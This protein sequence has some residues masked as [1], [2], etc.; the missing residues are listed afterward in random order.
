MSVRRGMNILDLLPMTTGLAP[1][2]PDGILEQIALLNIV[3]HRSTASPGFYLHE[4][5]L[6]SIADQFDLNT[7]NWM[8]SVPGVATGLPFRLSVARPPAFPATSGGVPA[9]GDFVQEDIPVQWALDIKVNPVSVVLPGLNAATI[10]S[11]DPMKTPSLQAAGGPPAARR[12]TLQASCVLRISGGNGGTLVQLMDAPDPLDPN[13]PSGGVVRANMQPNTAVIGNSQFGFKLDTLVADVSPTFTPAEIEARGKDES[14]MGISLKEL[15]FFLPL[16]TP[17]VDNM[18]VGGRDLLVGVPFGMQGEIA[19]DFSKDFPQHLNTYL[20]IEQFDAGTLSGVPVQTNPPLYAY[21]VPTGPQ[22]QLQRVR[23]K[24]NLNATIG[25]GVADMKVIGVWWEIPGGIEGNSDTTPWFDAPTDAVLRYRLRVVDATLVGQPAAQPSLPSAIPSGQTELQQIT[26]TFPRQSGSPSGDPPIV[27]ASANG[28]PLR[29]NVLH[30]R[31]PAHLLRQ[32]ALQTRNQAIAVR[33][34]LGGGSVPVVA[35]SSSTFTLAGL[36]NGAGPFELLVTDD[37]GEPGD[38]QGVRRIRIDV[39][40]AGPLAIGHQETDAAASPGLVSLEGEPAPLQPTRISDTFLA[41]EYHTTGARSTAPAPATLAGAKVTTQQG[42]DAEVEVLVP[43]GDNTPVPVPPTQVYVTRT[44]QVL[45]Q[46]GE[47]T[48]IALK[49]E[50]ENVT[51]APPGQSLQ[52]HQPLAYPMAINFQ[53][54]NGPPGATLEQQVAAWIAGLEAANPGVDR[55]FYVVG[56]T[57][58]LW[59]GANQVTNQQKN[60]ELA[61]QRKERAMAAVLAVVNDPARVMGRRETEAPVNWPTTLQ[62]A[63]QRMLDTRRLALPPG[64]APDGQPYL[65]T[66]ANGTPVWRHDWTRDATDNVQSGQHALAK[67]DL[68]RA[69][70]RCAEIFAIEAGQQ[71]QPS[72]P[73]PDGRSS[74]VTML[75]PGADGPVTQVV[76]TTPSNAQNDYRI[77]VK[78]RWDSPSA[79]GAADFIPTLAEAKVRW[80][81]TDTNLPSVGGQ[82]PALSSTQPGGPDYWEVLLNWAY[83]ASTGQTEATGALSIPYGKLQLI[84]DVWA[85]GL[86][87][88]PALAAKLD[89]NDITGT[90]AGDFVGGLACIAA[91]AV[92][93]LFINKDAGPGDHHGSVVFEKFTLSYKWNGA[94]HAAATTDYT[95]DLRIKTGIAGVFIVQGNLKLKYQGVGILFDGDDTGGLQDISLCMKDL[96]V[97]VVDPG[98]WTLGGPLGDLIRVA[99]S[100]LGNGS[101]WMEFDLEF[102]IDLG[103]IRLEG[104]VIRMRFESTPD[105]S[106]VELRGLTAV[107]EV[108][109]TLN[110]KGSVTIGDGGAFRAMLA[111][112]VIP[113][114]LSA[115]GAL[116]V[117]HDFVSVEVGIQL[118]VGIPLG[119]TGF[120]LFGFMGRFVANGTRDL[121]ACPHPDPVERQ[122]QWYG[123]QPDKKY[124]RL[125][126]QFAFGVGAVI[127]TL[128]DGGFSFNAEG[129][130]TLGFPDISVVFSI[131]AHLISQRK[132]Q[133]TAQGSNSGSSTR[134]LGMVVIEPDALMIAV[135]TTYKIPKIL[136]LK[137]PISAYF[138]LAGSNLAWYIRIGSDNG[139]GR[140]GD[141]VTIV[142]FPE[143]LDVKAWAFLM[144]EERELKQLGGTL[145]PSWAHIP[146]LDFDGFSI[147]F[148]AGFD[149]RWEAGPFS[150]EISAFMV[151]GLGTKPLLCAGAAGVSGSLDLVVVTLDVDGWLYFRIEE[152]KDPYAQGHFCASIDCWL[153]EISGCVDIEIGHD[154]NTG[155]P[156]PAA[157]ISGMDLVDHMAVVKGKA[158]VNGGGDVPVVWPDTVGV[159]KFTHY[160]A[161]TDPGA[162]FTREVPAPAALTAWSG[163]NQLK[164]A[165]RITKVE[166]Q[167]WDGAQWQAVGGPFPSAWWL[168]TH[169]KALIEAAPLGI[170]PSSEEGRELGLWTIDP[171]PWARWLTPESLDVPGNPANTFGQL[172]DPRPAP[173]PSCALGKDREWAYDGFGAFHAA[174]PANT[175]YP[176][177]FNAVAKLDSHHTLAELIALGSA[178]GFNYA[179]GAVAALAGTVVHEGM[180]ITQGWRF[181]AFRKQGAMACTVPLALDL[182]KT[183]LE[184]ELLLQVCI[185]RGALPPPTRRVCDTMPARDEWIS[186]FTGASSAVYEGKME[187]A[188]DGGERVVRL[189]SPMSG[190]HAAGAVDEVAVNLDPGKDSVQLTAFD[191]NGTI[192]GRIQTRDAGRQWLTLPGQGIVAIR[193]EATMGLLPTLVYAVCW[194]SAGGST[195]PA[196][197]GRVCDRM[198]EKEGE[199]S[200][201]AGASGAKYEGRMLGRKIGGEWTT[202][203]LGRV[204]GMHLAAAVD[205]VAAEVTPEPAST[206]GAGRVMLVALD[207]AGQIL[208][209]V[210]SEGPGRQWL[211][212]RHPGI[213][214]ILLDPNMEAQ[215]P[216][217][218]HTVCWGAQTVRT[219]PLSLYDL[220]AVEAAPALLVRAYDE[221]AGVLALQGEPVPFKETTRLPC[222]V[223][224]Y[225]LPPRHDGK[226]WTRIEVAPWY[227]GNVSLVALC[228]LTQEAWQAQHDDQAFQDGLV[229][230]VQDQTKNQQNNEPGK[231][232]ALDAASSYRVRVTWEYQ[233]WQSAK[234]GDDPPSPSAGGWLAGGTEE[235]A[236]NTAAFGVTDPNTLPSA[237]T[238]TLDMDPAQGGPGFDER[239]FD[240][241]GL[242]RYI[243]H[244]SPTHEDP[245]HFLDDPIGFWFR[246]DHLRSLVSKYDGRELKVKVYHTRPP[247]GS[248]NGYTLHVDGSRHI[249]DVTCDDPALPGY[250]ADNPLWQ[251]TT[252]AWTV[253]DAQL[254]EVL[255]AL[256]CLNVNPGSGAS[257][258]TVIADL[259]PNSEYD[260]LLNTVKPGDSSVKEVLVARSHFRTSRYRNPTGML[261]AL[262]FA[263]EPDGGTPNDAITSF[264]LQAKYAA[265][266]EPLVSDAA[267]DEAL[268]DCGMDPW[269]LPP[270][271]R[272]TVIWRQ[273]GIAATPWEIAGVL[274]EADEPVWRAGMRTGALNEPEPAP[275]LE[276]ASLQVFRTD[277][278]QII[279]NGQPQWSS[280]RSPL[281]GALKEAVRNA[282]GTRVLFAAAASAPRPALSSRL[283]DI[284]LKFREHGAAGASGKVQI[285]NRPATVALEL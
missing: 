215:Q 180:A 102:A 221:Q 104:A 109:N 65:Q 255:D 217:L 139:P 21:A 155:I 211:T 92:I 93:G 63:P 126:G 43:S 84:S 168:P 29:H 46:Y 127:G 9:P 272:T 242:A 279:V 113:A 76:T 36:P 8:L 87:F 28:G 275:R 259:A 34:T 230:W 274:L 48:P 116:A 27:D 33:W 88:G 103:V 99:S 105:K 245:P 61:D 11:S 270:A 284:E 236:F 135:R 234:P 186:V 184:G 273:T 244:V 150:L 74:R 124:K 191:A 161:D 117:D 89:E 81:P 267:L 10:N 137:V 262:G 144:F 56:R 112:E 78:V 86:A 169:R 118:P 120:G 69:G 207:A 31:G 199:Y 182:S 15:T 129:A 16:N 277:D 37:N 185:E 71:Q 121:S 246:V 45:Y 189:F 95:V 30:L 13:A 240:P 258:V 145:I 80:R 140:A 146:P 200:S 225:K 14:F 232:I 196:E 51:A 68:D 214:Q 91:G 216:P 193:L 238:T 237:Q 132:S 227:R 138:P 108:P 141:P 70:Y 205:E 171:A 265:L 134:I 212:I 285:F 233:G 183:L 264:N 72:I 226:A 177:K 111:L 110:G 73:G 254:Q 198:P 52:K 176:S 170:P 41:R 42:T 67:A 253:A 12:V 5:T 32:V 136:E 222:R 122:L 60:D 281:G 148:G 50:D 192:V 278:T 25:G 44:V 178:A 115:Y 179:P 250:V 79:T 3:D 19:A 213:A 4:G 229:D 223:Y 123:L 47:S 160:V 24:F 77:T 59:Y 271:P 83:D 18:T 6:Q 152:G 173:V 100:R 194:G 158:A 125:S 282:A 107:V 94:P 261:R 210:R 157:P 98:T 163:S 165:Y 49:N 172:C 190:R 260:L 64:N 53:G 228:G 219:T 257:K 202:A 147:G 167:K 156:K 252:D 62:G 96:S 58:D 235:F 23:A 133:A 218:L 142:L 243:T 149:L 266:A 154:S 231:D 75:V 143:V 40:P 195:G 204:A 55:K 151:V 206:T 187:C 181:P 268:R 130:L 17:L 283:F 203:L 38:T 128:P 220:V 97:Q 239:T 247:A 82:Q 276:I 85:S 256:P 280:S 249:L 119:G 197:P 66:G 101:D 208:A 162:T 7:A 175:P 174:P 2:V 269:P 114:K 106:A 1:V 39:T 209:R 241:R 164:Y 131:D 201:F 251:V 54:R 22:A 26:V 166:L 90:E 188:A 224:R 248:L 263:P 20:T 153:F 159:L 57:D 35:R